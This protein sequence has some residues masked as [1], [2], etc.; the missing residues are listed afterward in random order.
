MNQQEMADLLEIQQ[1][2]SRYMAF[3]ARKEMDKERWLEVFT[4]DGV[5]NAFGT[6][7]RLDDFPMLLKSAPPGQYIGN[8]PLVEFSGDTASG[9]QH[10]V[11][12]VQTSHEMRLAWYNDEYART[13]DGWRIRSR[14]TTFMRRSGGFDHGNAHDPSRYVAGKEIR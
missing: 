3:S 11:F 13:P 5:Y 4:Y 9:V 6:P 14:S 12:I 1:L 7:Y 10:Y 2:C 8:T